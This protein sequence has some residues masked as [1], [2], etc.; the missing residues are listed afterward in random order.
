MSNEIWENHP[1][2]NTLYAFIRRKSD[3]FIYIVDTGSN[4]FEAFIV[5]NIATYDLPMTDDG[6]D[7]YSVDFPSD[8]SIGVHR[9]SIFLQEGGTP[10]LADRVIAQGEFYWDGTAEIDLSTI[11]IDIGTI[12]GTVD[13][14]LTVVR[15]QEN[16]FD[17]DNP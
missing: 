6:G 4:T 11:D 10:V 12:D 7:F 5:S 9:I 2:G 16:L 13:E 17:L 14:I 1:T 3:D 15:I 8:I